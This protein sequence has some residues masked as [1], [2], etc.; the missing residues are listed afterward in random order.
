MSKQMLKMATSSLLLLLLVGIL[1]VPFS[2]NTNLAGTE[3]DVLG[4]TSQRPQIQK[5]RENKIKHNAEKLDAK[6]LDVEKLE[7]PSKLERLPLHEEWELSTDTGEGLEG[8]IVAE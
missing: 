4:E 6:K 3:R 1:I 8:T 2:V 5:A 7:T